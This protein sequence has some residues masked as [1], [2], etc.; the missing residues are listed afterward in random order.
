MACRCAR[1]LCTP[2]VMC[3]VYVQ[4]IATTIAYIGMVNS[5]FRYILVLL[6]GCQLKGK[7]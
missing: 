4:P 7:E 3:H 2:A 5:S 6:N 1:L